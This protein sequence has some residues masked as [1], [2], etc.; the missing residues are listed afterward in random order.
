M[1]HRKLA[2]QNEMA[3]N[4]DSC[5]GRFYCIDKSRKIKYIIKNCNMLPFR[6]LCVW[7]CVLCHCICPFYTELSLPDKKLKSMYVCMVYEIF[8]MNKCCFLKSLYYNQ[9]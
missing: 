1:F 9:R 2:V 5:Y 6:V 4:K 7:F 8:Y 3:L